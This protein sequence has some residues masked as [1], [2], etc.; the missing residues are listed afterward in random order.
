[1]IEKFLCESTLLIDDDIME[2]LIFLFYGEAA[3]KKLDTL[4]EK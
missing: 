2:L 1:M 3:Q 4:I